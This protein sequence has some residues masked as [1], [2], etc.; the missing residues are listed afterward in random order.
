M[1]VLLAEV[2]L[3]PSFILHK[4]EYAVDGVSYDPLSGVLVIA[5]DLADAA[6][7]RQVVFPGVVEGCTVSVA[8]RSAPRDGAVVERDG[9]LYLPPLSQG[10]SLVGDISFAPPAAEGLPKPKIKV[11]MTIRGRQ[12]GGG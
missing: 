3:D 11:A 10:E 6:R 12:T 5:W 8:L 2:P 7:A 1:S 4:E 9:S